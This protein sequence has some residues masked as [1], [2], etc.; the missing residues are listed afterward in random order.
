MILPAELEAAKIS[1]AEARKA[2]EDYEKLEGFALTIE[3]EKLTKI[4]I[5]V[6]EAYLGIDPAFDG[7]HQ[8]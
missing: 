4:F 6:T 5:R 2:L 3:Y 8:G 1:M 7:S